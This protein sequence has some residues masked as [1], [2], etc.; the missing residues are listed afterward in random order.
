[1]NR[2]LPCT[3]RFR[4]ALRGA[5]GA[6]S[7]A[8]AGLLVACTPALDWRDVRPEGALVQLQMPCKPNGQSRDVN[9]GG[10]RV[11]LALHA[12][13][14]GQLTWGLAAADM[15]DPAR[16]GPALA[17]LAASAAGNLATK[18]SSLQP[19]AISG[20]TPNPASGLQRLSG[21]LP[22]GKPAQMQVVVFTRGTWVYQASVLGEKVDE[23]AAQ[24]YFASLRFSP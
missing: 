23:A 12:C 16:V 5:A 18:G 13:A 7:A 8:L 22:D 14:A 19:L 1:M 9:L 20:A 24:T 4:S 17:E 6:A 21:R 3:P 11:N 2:Q 10:S 15:T